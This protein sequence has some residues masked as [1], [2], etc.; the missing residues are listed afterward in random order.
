MGVNTL[1]KNGIVRKI[2][3]Q[4]TI[5][6]IEAKVG[7]V[8]YN[9]SMCRDNKGNT[10]ISIRSCIRNIETYQ[11]YLHPMKYQNFLHIGKLNEDTLEITELKEIKP[12]ED[13]PGFQWG[14]EDIRLFWRQDGLH[15]I[16][17]ILPITATGPKANQAEILINHEKGT[18]KLLKD[19]GFPR[20]VSEKNWMPPEKP[21]RLFDFVY[22]STQ[23]VLDGQILG[24][25][26]DLFLHNGTAL[27]PYEDGFLSLMHIVCSIKNERSYV[28]VAAKWN[29]EGNVTHISQMFHFN[30][31]WREELKETIE[32]ASGILWSKGK[33]GEEILVGLGV[34]DELTGFCRIPVSDFEWEPYEDT[35]YYNWDWLEPPN[36]KEVPN[37]PTPDPAS[38]HIVPSHQP[39]SSL[40]TS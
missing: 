39:E 1:V 17:V 19:F 29:K 12:E 27:I 15:G 13:Y 23:V 3:R 21:E 38:H 30:I 2:N 8:H 9:P 35:M 20:G 31:G 5:V 7:E 6:P 37:L 32:F 14:V 4:V 10:W 11:G 34:K 16:G 33:E 25:K 28:T 36:R 18:Y 26:N 22:S 40:A 24:K